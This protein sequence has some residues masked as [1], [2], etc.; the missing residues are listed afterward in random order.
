MSGDQAFL[1]N[2]R[3]IADEA[4]A[5]NADDVDRNARFPSETIDALREAKALSAYVPEELGGGGVSFEALATACLELG[6]R[7]G[8]ARWSSPCT[9]SRW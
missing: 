7:C 8:R 9:R 3:R 6:R 1:E 4:A 5:P 2:V